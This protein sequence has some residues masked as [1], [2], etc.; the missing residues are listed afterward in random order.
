MEAQCTARAHDWLKNCWPWHSLHSSLF[1]LVNFNSH[2]KA[3]G[4]FPLACCVPMF[5][6]F[7]SFGSSWNF[8]FQHANSFGLGDMTFAATLGDFSINSMQCSKF[9]AMQQCICSD[10]H[11]ANWLQSQHWVCF[12]TVSDKFGLSGPGSIKQT[13]FETICNCFWHFC[14]EIDALP[15]A[16]C[17]TFHQME[18]IWDSPKNTSKKIVLSTSNRHPQQSK[19]ILRQIPD[20]WSHFSSHFSMS[21]NMQ[22]LKQIET[23]ANPTRARNQSSHSLR[24]GALLPLPSTIA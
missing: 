1:S 4:K 18:A 8:H 23:N 15:S 10:K 7:F 24:C 9:S 21:L 17:D 13:Q 19:T 6:N 14:M 20:N 2:V 22:V 3:C 12:W 5:A 11:M 16:F